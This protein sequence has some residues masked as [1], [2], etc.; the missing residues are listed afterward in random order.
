MSKTT[1]RDADGNVIVTIEKRSG[2]KTFF[3]EVLILVFGVALFRNFG[4]LPSPWAAVGYAGI[5]LLALVII[6]GLVF[7]WAKKRWPAKFE[8]KRR[9]RP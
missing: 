9:K 5:T 1:V 4:Q 8:T 2:L 3:G 7:A 6:L